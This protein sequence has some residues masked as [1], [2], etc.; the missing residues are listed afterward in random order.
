M[1]SRTT[2]AAIA[3]AALVAVAGCGGGN[4]KTSSSAS[5]PPPSTQASTPA[6]APTGGAPSYDAVKKLA[7][8]DPKLTSVCAKGQ[9]D[10]DIEGSAPGEQYKRFICGNTEVFDYSN[11]KKNFARDYAA[12]R[13]EAQ[14]PI[15]VLDKEAFV[16]VPTVLASPGFAAKLKKQCGCGA[17]VNA[18]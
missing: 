14:Q 17:V 5:S 18:G 2:L 9:K 4:D 10:L 11:G 13:S 15:W 7:L 12:V 16:F 1:K 6:P 8:A 3:A